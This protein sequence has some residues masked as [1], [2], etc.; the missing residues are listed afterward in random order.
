MTKQELDVQAVIEAMPVPMALN[1]SEQQ[2][3][4]LNSAFVRTFGY[5]REDIP[6]LSDWWPKAYPDTCYRNSVIAAWGAEL[7]RLHAGASHFRPMELSIQCKDGQAKFVQAY[8]ANLPGVESRDHL[9]ILNDVSEQA[10]LNGELSEQ[11]S[12]LELVVN[13]IPGPVSMVDG[14]GRYVFLNKTYEKWFGKFPAE[15]VGKHIS[16][17][18]SPEL[19]SRVL[20]YVNRAFSGESVTYETIF[21]SVDGQRRHVQSTLSPY[22]KNDG[23]FDGYFLISHDISSLKEAEKRAL[24]TARL[25]SLGE[26]AAGVAHEVNNPLAIISGATG[27]LEKYRNDPKKFSDKVKNIEDALQRISKIVSGLRNFS[28]TG[29]KTVH[30]PIC[31]AKVVEGSL[32]LVAMSAR[33]HSVPLSFE[34]NS[35]AVFLGDELE[36]SQ[37]LVN[38][39]T[40]AIYAV[41]ELPE[42]WVKVSLRE[43]QSGL[44]LQILDSGKGIPTAIQ[45]KIFQPFFTTKPVGEGTGI[46]LSISKGILEEHGAEIALKADDPHTCFEIRFPKG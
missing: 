19:Y 13:S 46:G 22:K 38:L 20:P 31:L 21:H 37:V 40:N 15:I 2:I 24:H 32:N 8:A 16:E 35:A 44:L 14:Q 42:K 10:A 17:V 29:E 28:R 4:Y 3:T 43:T 6:T 5:S 1:N 27:L 9:V 12:V 45:E 34:G 39:L 36:I 7:D 25:A 33:V 11:K 23:T 26:M 41:K 30:L 18:L